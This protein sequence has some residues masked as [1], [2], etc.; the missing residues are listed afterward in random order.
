MIIIYHGKSNHSQLKCFDFLDGAILK[1]IVFN[2]KN[3]NVAK[4][5][6]EYSPSKI[7]V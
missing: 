3:A 4:Q 2:G 7:G 1:S 5:N 6:N